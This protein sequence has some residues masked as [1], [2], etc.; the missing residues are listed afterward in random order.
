LAHLQVVIVNKLRRGESFALELHDDDH[1]ETFW[2]NERTPL[3]FRFSGNRRPTLNH[4][5]LEALAAETG[6]TGV[7]RITHEPPQAEP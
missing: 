7:L 5:W 2:I 1:L 4:A 6:L 3:E